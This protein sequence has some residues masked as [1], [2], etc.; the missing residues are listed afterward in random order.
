MQGTGQVPWANL[1]PHHH[2]HA[3]QPLAT[4]DRLGSSG[5]PNVGPLQYGDLS[6]ASSAPIRASGERRSVASWSSPSQ[7]HDRRPFALGPRRR[8]RTM[9]ADAYGAV[10]DLPSV[11]YLFANLA[12][13]T[14]RTWS[15]AAKGPSTS[16]AMLRDGYA[17]SREPQ[18]RDWPNCSSK[19]H[20]RRA[21]CSC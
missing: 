21:T 15:R 4:R 11:S 16:A 9:H 17:V 20:L 12:L 10:F 8:P 6:D 7:R 2:R 1:P 14:S 5:P 3:H 18:H 13:S 19:V